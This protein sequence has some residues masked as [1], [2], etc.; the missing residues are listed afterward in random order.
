[1]SFMNNFINRPKGTNCVREILR[2][3]FLG[4][5]LVNNNFL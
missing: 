3:V 2:K 1:M 5:D 4:I